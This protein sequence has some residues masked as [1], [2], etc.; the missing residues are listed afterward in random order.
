MDID[1]DQRSNRNFNVSNSDIL[2]FIIVVGSSR[3]RR[4]LTEQRIAVDPKDS[5]RSIDGTR[6]RTC[7]SFVCVYRR[8]PRS[9]ASSRFCVHNRKRLH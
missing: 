3:A 8:N 4:S 5:R 7:V 2:L 1:Y 9:P 6:A